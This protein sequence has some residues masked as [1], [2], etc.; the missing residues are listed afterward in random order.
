MTRLLAS[1][2]IILYYITNVSASSLNQNFEYEYYLPPQKPQKI[3]K[4]DSQINDYKQ[5]Y[6][7]HNS[8]WY[9]KNEN[10]KKHYILFDTNYT[11]SAVIEV[12]SDEVKYPQN[13]NNPSEELNY[14]GDMSLKSALG[15]GISYGY[16][17]TNYWSVELDTSFIRFNIAEFDSDYTKSLDT[18]IDDNSDP[19]VAINYDEIGP[20]AI[21]EE[22]DTLK[23]FVGSANLVLNLE[24]K[25]RYKPFIG[26]G[27]GIGL[28]GAS[29]GYDA[30]NYILYKA[31]M[32]FRLSKNVNFYL[33]GKYYDFANVKYSYKV[34]KDQM[35]AAK[36]S[37]NERVYSLEHNLDFYT[38]NIGYIFKF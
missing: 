4:L 6:G 27:Y 31:G 28:L 14:E 5:Y 10:L 25:T 8:R 9:R 20:E 19:P 29:A 34:I 24:N 1:S 16:N 12:S 36:K 37:F 26:V 7:D 17:V 32:Y 21:A 2:I 15:L 35:L 38:I 30:H 18:G 11:N 23:A 13:T 3:R 33:A 22:N